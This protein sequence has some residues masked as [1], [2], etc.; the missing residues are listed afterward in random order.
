MSGAGCGA[1]G[2]VMFVSQRPL[3][4]GTAGQGWT[5][6]ERVTFAYS[7]HFTEE[8]KNSA[9][10]RIFWAKMEN[11]YFLAKID[12]GTA[13]T[14]RAA[15]CQNCQYSSK[16]TVRSSVIHSVENSRLRGCSLYSMR[17]APRHG[18][19]PHHSGILDGP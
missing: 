10:H 14:V 15:L 17:Y 8:Y 12:A 18:V 6:F 2:P 3:C 7:G 5:V 4:C 11:A 13:A 1:A 9:F 16:K 19:A